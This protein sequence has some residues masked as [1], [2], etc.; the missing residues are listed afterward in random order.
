MYR[1]LSLIHNTRELS[2]EINPDLADQVVQDE[3]EKIISWILNIPD[4]ECEYE[5]SKTIK[6]EWEGLAS[7][8]IE[9][10]DKYWQFGDTMNEISVMKLRKDFEEKYNTS[11]THTQFAEALKDQGYY[12][13]KNMVANIIPVLQKE[14]KAQSLL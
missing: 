11:M 6:N 1:R 10:M 2:Y 3:G 13:N 5:V 14:E 4:S 12:I 7:P 9:Y 8:E